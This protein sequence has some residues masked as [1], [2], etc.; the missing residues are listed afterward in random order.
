VIGRAGGRE[1]VSEEGRER[2]REI[3]IQVLDQN[4]SSTKPVGLPKIML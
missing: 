2:E 4:F 1:G 3:L